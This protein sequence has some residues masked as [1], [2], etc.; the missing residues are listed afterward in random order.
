MVWCQSLVWYGLGWVG[1]VWFGLVWFGIRAYA[2]RSV[3]V[4]ECL[5]DEEVPLGGKAGLGL[6]MDGV[7]GVV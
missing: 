5:E 7:E 4:S 3:L 1:L 2:K 6:F